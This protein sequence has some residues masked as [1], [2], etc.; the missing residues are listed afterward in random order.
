M[1]TLDVDQSDSIENVR[2][3]IQDKEGIP[4]YLQ[5]LFFA[6]TEL[7]DG[8]TLL[9]Y[10]IQ[11]ESTLYLVHGL[12]HCVGGWYGIYCTPDGRGVLQIYLNN[13]NLTGSLP[14][15]AFEHLESLEHLDLNTNKLSNVPDFN[16]PALKYLYLNNNA[17]SIIPNFEHLESLQVL[18]LRGNH[19]ASIPQS[20]CYKP[21]LDI[22]K[23][24]GVECV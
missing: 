23:D 1:I 11:Q 18:D 24:D 4:I 19:L 15:P 10:N 17:L 21:G 8:R 7:K 2:T 20:L 9:D 22:Y 12:D 13:N 16:L 3:K 14:P 5:R 6:F